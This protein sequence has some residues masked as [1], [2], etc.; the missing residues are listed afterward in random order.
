MKQEDLVVC[1]FRY[2]LGRSTYVVS[3]MI[4]HILCHWNGLCPA[5][6]KLIKN[7]IEDALDR[8]VC[9]MRM[10]CEAWRHC[11]EDIEKREASSD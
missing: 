7:E 2:C 11:L 4:E 9:G 8:D 6:Q 3:E 10:D 1:A 5:Y